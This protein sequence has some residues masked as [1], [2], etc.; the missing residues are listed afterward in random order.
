MLISAIDES[1]AVLLREQ[2][3]RA[4]PDATIFA[5]NGLA[6][7]AYFDPADG[8]I[9]VTLDARVL[10]ASAT[11]DP[12]AYP[13]RGR[14]SCPPTG[15]TIGAPEPSAIYGYEAMGLMLRAITRATD[16][17]HEAAE[18]SKVV[19][20]ILSTPRIHSLLGIYGIDSAGDTTIH[21]YGIYRIVGGRLSF[22]KATG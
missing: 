8:G 3:A 10:V 1:S 21:R 4:L 15:G 14:R 9:P 16:R 18:R 11:L 6:D 13:P 12:S 5:S 7:S 22:L 17:G 19:A 2:I 20:A